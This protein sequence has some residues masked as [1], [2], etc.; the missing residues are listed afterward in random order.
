MTPT[1]WLSR[2]LLLSLWVVPSSTTHAQG[3]ADEV[4]AWFIS[5]FAPLWA[6]MDEAD[7]ERISTFWTEEFRDH[8][9]TGD[10]NMWENT[11]E[12]WK[13]NIERNKAEGLRRSEVV[14]IHV[15]EISGRAALIRTVWSDYGEDGLVEDPY[16]C[17]T[18]IAG[19]F[20]DTW[21]FTNYF[22]VECSPE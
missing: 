2:L 15:E 16:Y 20:G 14:S 4:K 7:P 6:D 21:K 5:E 19:R 11:T 22:T 1:N 12:Q 9:V 18:Y 13:R 8:P 17:G 10:S 3:I